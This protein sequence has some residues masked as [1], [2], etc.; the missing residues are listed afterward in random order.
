[1]NQQ[2]HHGH[3]ENWRPVFILFL[4]LAAS[5][6]SQDVKLLAGFEYDQMQTWGWNGITI[7]DNISPMGGSY[8]TL[9]QGDATEGLWAVGKD[10]GSDAVSWY[11]T[12]PPVPENSLIYTQGKV[13]YTFGFLESWLGS[14]WSGYD[15]LRIDAKSTV[16]SCVVWLTLQDE[17]TSP[18]FIRR[19][20]VPAN[21]WVTLEFNLAEAA[22]E[23]KVPLSS[24]G[25]LYWGVDT[26]KGR[27]LNL[28]KMAN[29]QV[30]VPHFYHVQAQRLMVDNMRLL[31]A[32]V[33]DGTALTVIRDTTPFQTVQELPPQSPV[34]TGKY[35]GARNTAPLTL[36]A[37][38]AIDL[39][40][41]SPSYAYLPNAYSISAVDNDHII[42]GTGIFGS[43]L[44]SV[45]GGQNWTSVPGFFHSI[46]APANMIAGA[47]D[48]LLGFYTERCG[49]GGV[50]SAMY[51]RNLKFDGSDWQ[52][53][54]QKMITPTSWHCAEWKVNGVRLPNGRIWMFS[55]HQTRY[56]DI[57]LRAWYSD[58]EGNSWRW[59]NATGLADA[60]AWRTYGTSSGNLTG[61]EWWVE[62]SS[63]WSYEGR[64]A[65]LGTVTTSFLFPTF[66]PLLIPYGNEVASFWLDGNSNSVKWSHS[67]GAGW[68]APAAILSGATHRPSGGVYHSATGKLYFA[69]GQK[70]YQFDGSNS[71][72]DITPALC[73]ASVLSLSGNRLLNFWQ[74]QNGAQY[75]IC[76]NT[77]DLPDG[78]WSPACTLSTELHSCNLASTMYA[79]E[80]FFPVAW[81]Y[82]G[83]TE[84]W[85][86]FQRIPN[87]NPT[88][89]EKPQVNATAAL[90]LGS[91]SNPVCGQTVFS[92]RLLKPGAVSLKVYD[93][94]GRW[95]RSL[96]QT[97][98]ASGMHHVKWDAQ[99]LAA[100]L[101]VARIK[102]EGMD[103][104]KKIIVLK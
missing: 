1:M 56:R 91:S 104:A 80:N 37:P 39:T 18:F 5:L 38:V 54:T 53:T 86:K 21:Q 74:V 51:F 77:K 96:V 55:A 19:Y 94:S 33:N 103:I 10:F 50:S 25:A 88:R 41:T 9:F 89:A 57:R 72:V 75:Y 15:R 27:K 3:L 99:G 85:I 79:P 8:G 14:D 43:V 36:G 97:P 93:H 28:S 64:T 98:Q 31:K 12:S 24:Q 23:I 70:V 49:G 60:Q 13:F 52:L 47:G 7:N 84:K 100:G 71:P 32:G 20:V 82:T 78:A 16:D 76:Y 45:N 66:F 4:M 46:N 90:F 17:L 92:Y 83:S 62:N 68:T 48:D 58:D 2:K 59:P 11:L 81:A 42:M 63:R 67:D 61:A 69:D 73:K 95:V 40:S 35:A 26:L 87:D 101:Y 6:F 22:K 29:F 102:A 34:W 44:K 65:S 30:N